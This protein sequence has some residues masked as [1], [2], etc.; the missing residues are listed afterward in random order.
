MQSNR[1]HPLSHK[2][3]TFFLTFCCVFCMSNRFSRKLIKCQRKNDEK[4]QYFAHA[5]HILVLLFFF[6]QFFLSFIY[7]TNSKTIIALLSNCYQHSAHAIRFNLHF[8]YLIF[9]PMIDKWNLLIEFHLIML[10]SWTRTHTNMHGHT[11]GQIDAKTKPIWIG[12]N[13]T[14]KWKAFCLP[15]QKQNFMQSESFFKRIA[16]EMIAIDRR[17]RKTFDFLNFFFFHFN[18]KNSIFFDMQFNTENLLANICFSRNE[19]SR[20]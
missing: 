19:C 3:T 5:F 20:L 10:I 8:P 1:G 11:T 12:S 16:S 2:F 14:R 4:Q 7:L 15:W 6:T 9:T 18:E 17:H 13:F